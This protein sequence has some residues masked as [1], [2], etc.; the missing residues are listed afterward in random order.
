M[1][2]TENASIYQMK[3]CHFMYETY[4]LKFYGENLYLMNTNRNHIPDSEEFVLL[5]NTMDR[6]AKNTFS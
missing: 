4:N 6:F 2:L 1:I 3:N 5:I